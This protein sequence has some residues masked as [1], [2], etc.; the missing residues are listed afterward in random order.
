MSSVVFTIS[1]H[2]AESSAS[3][4]PPQ[5]PKELSKTLLTAAGDEKTRRCNL[6]VYEATPGGNGASH[7]GGTSQ[8]LATLATS[9]AAY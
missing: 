9:Y 7:A 5:G 1:L 6:L 3:C 2:P 8:K 4:I